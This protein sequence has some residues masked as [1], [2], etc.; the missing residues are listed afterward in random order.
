MEPVQDIATLV[1]R[2]LQAQVVGPIYEENGS[3]ARR[4]K[5][6]G[7]SGYGNPKGGHCRG[8]GVRG[9]GSEREDLDGTLAQS[10]SPEG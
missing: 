10:R 4:R 3:T 1:K 8:A 9:T 6:C 2:R 5:S 7:H